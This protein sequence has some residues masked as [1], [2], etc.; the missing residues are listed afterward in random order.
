[1]AFSR[2]ICLFFCKLIQVS[3]FVPTTEMIKMNI[4]EG[5]RSSLVAHWL[6][7]PGTM[8]QIPVEEKKI[9]AFVFEL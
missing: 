6:S 1:M 2:L 5:Q 8:A 9:S 4:L 7:V 3:K